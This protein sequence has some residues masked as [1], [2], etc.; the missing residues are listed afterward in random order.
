MTT[1][2]LRSKIMKGI[3][4]TALAVTVVTGF[5]PIAAKAAEASASAAS[6][7]VPMEIT[8]DGVRLRRAANTNS[9]ILELMY[10]GETF[11]VD[12]YYNQTSKG[13][14]H[15]KRVKTGGVGYASSVYL[16]RK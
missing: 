6:S 12:D 15:G 14:Y 16:K 10:K 3:L 13:W 8:G 7:Y 5:S 4:T 2:N 9:D 1:K 11:N